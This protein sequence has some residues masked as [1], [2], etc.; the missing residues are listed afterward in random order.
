MA[1]HAAGAAPDD[2]SLLIAVPEAGA[3]IDEFDANAAAAVGF[4]VQQG[5]PVIYVGWISPH[6]LPRLAAA[7]AEAAERTLFVA[8]AGN[9]SGDIDRNPVS[10]AAWDHPNLLV[11]TTDRLMHLGPRDDDVGHG[12]RSVDVV[13]SGTGTELRTEAG[14]EWFG[15]SSAA[16]AHAA[17]LAAA[18]AAEHP[19][20]PP[21]E[22]RRRVLDQ[23]E[24]PLTAE[25]AALLASCTTS[26]ACL[27]F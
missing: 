10:P 16:A 12:R 19:R 23:A 26:S 11:V 14:V 5:V 2:C 4:A 22:L 13:A 21:Q 3:S 7:M 18:L 6:P 8:P 25:L 20:A 15:D 27:R 1:R 24:R 17:G 9:H